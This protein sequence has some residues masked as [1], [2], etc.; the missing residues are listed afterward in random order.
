[1]ER[2]QEQEVVIDLPAGAEREEHTTHLYTC[3]HWY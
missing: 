1:M 3:L 2:E